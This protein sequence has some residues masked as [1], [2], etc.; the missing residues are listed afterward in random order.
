MEGLQDTGRFLAFVQAWR[1][2]LDEFEDGCQALTAPYAHG[3]QP[4]LGAAATH[5]V[6]HRRQDPATGRPDRVAER[7][8][9][10][11]HVQP[12]EICLV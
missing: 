3:L 5:L 6:K 9:G 11:I 2:L 12:V 10:A 4:E 7:D 8:A 1:R